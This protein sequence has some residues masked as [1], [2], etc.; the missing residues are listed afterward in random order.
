MSSASDPSRREISPGQ[1]HEWCREGGCVQ[2]VD[3]RSG[4]E[5]A[6]KRIAGAKSMPLEELGARQVELERGKPIIVICER[7]PRGARACEELRRLGWHDVANLSGGMQ[8]W[9]SARLPIEA[10][11]H[12][13]WALERQVRVAAGSLLLVGAG[14][15]W[16]IHPD[17]F[18]LCAFV[19]A[20]LIFAGITEW[21][22][23]ALLLARAP[24]NRRPR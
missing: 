14:L 23:M 10:D 13:P 24:W 7:G 1:L 2:L 16:L 4:G 9:S 15:G 17:F 6:G 3:V 22:G 20:G 8:A 21:C 12:A 19:G 18:A 5:F 11:A